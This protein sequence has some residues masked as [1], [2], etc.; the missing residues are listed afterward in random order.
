MCCSPARVPARAGRKRVRHAA[1]ALR[2]TFP[3]STGLPRQVSSAQIRVFDSVGLFDEIHLDLV[4]FLLG[5][6]VC[7]FDHLKGA[8]VVLENPQASIGK[9]AIHLPSRIVK[10]QATDLLRL[11]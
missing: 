7:L 8:P 11:A 1:S 6:G 2:H 4:P 3:P 5:D 9:G 10:E